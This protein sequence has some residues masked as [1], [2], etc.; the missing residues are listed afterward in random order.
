[1]VTFRQRLAN[2]LYN[3]IIMQSLL[4]WTT[5]LMMGG[6]PAVISLALSCLS[7]VL[8]WIF[9]VTFSA[10]VA[11]VVTFVSS[12][13]VPLVSHPWLAVSLFGAPALLGA[14]WGQ[15]IGYII[16][17]SYLAHTSTEKRRN[18]PANLRTSLAKLDAE[19][20]IYKS[21]LVQW[22][23]LLILGN[24]YKIGSSYLALA[25]LASPAFSCKL[26]REPNFYDEK[27]FSVLDT[28]LSYQKF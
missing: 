3:S 14:F 13:P 2:M 21:G 8:M 6:Y 25:W 10:A 23:V 27:N 9:S 12:S 20:W 17:K 11:F 15:H 24:Y 26:H 4:L 18:L 5:S 7:L 19:R 16:L 22:F 1:M 28:F